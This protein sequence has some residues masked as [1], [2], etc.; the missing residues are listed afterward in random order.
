LNAPVDHIAFGTPAALR[1][2]VAECLHLSAFYASMGVN[3][4]EVGDDAGLEVSTRKATAA[5]RQAISVM[6]MLKE[7]NTKLRPEGTAHER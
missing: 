4:S 2:F 1:E 6:A 7:A 3:Y 5:M